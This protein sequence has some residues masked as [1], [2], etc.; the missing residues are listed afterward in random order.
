VRVFPVVNINDGRGVVEHFATITA[1]MLKVHFFAH[2]GVAF[3]DL[4]KRLDGRVIYYTRL[5]EIDD[6]F[7]GIFFD[8]EFLLEKTNGSEE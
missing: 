5:F 3:G 1:K 8:F 6:Y 7:V 2:F 4:V